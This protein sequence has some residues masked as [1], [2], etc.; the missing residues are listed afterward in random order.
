ML[1]I[2]TNSVCPGKE[3]TLTELA[4][5]TMLERELDVLVGRVA[6]YKNLHRMEE[7][8]ERSHEIQQI[9]IQNPAPGTGKFCATM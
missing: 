7:R 1:M 3:W 4:D 5:D 9:K 6:I 8:A 2:S